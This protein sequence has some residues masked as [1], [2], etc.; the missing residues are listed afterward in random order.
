MKWPPRRPKCPPG[1]K[2][3]VKRTIQVILGG[4]ATVGVIRVGVDIIRVVVIEDIKEIAEEIVDI[5]VIAG[6]IADTKVIEDIKVVMIEGTIE[7]IGM[8]IEVMVEDTMVEAD[9]MVEVDII[10]IEIEAFK[11]LVGNV[12]D[13]VSD[14][15]VN[16]EMK[17]FFYC[18]RAMIF[19]MIYSL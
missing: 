9:I 15:F 17:E 1:S 8:I 3:L 14:F 16:S 4:E 19:L 11:G 10:R 5:K 18:L 12:I 7:D 13:Y 2:D 6:V